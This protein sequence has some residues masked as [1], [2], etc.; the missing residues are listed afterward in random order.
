MTAKKMFAVASLL[1]AICLCGAAWE[2]AAAPRV[3]SARPESPAVGE[4]SGR[5]TFEGEPPPL[6]E[7]DMSKDPVCAA[8]NKP[9]VYLEDGKVNRDGTVPNAFVYIQAGAEKFSLTP[10]KKPAELN[11]VRCV[12]KPHVVGV[13][14][15]Q[16]LDIVSS[17][18]TTHNVRV[19]P[20]LNPEWNH[21]QPPGGAPLKKKFAHPEI[22][23]F[24]D[25]NQHPWM[26]AYIGVTSNPFFAVS[27]DDGKFVIQGV[28]PGQFTLGAWTATFGTQERK[29]TVEP[30]QTVKADFVFKKP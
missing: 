27:G 25:C 24:A 6:Q 10:P 4:I 3:P 22:M 29:V 21:S 7:V 5:I 16:E 1:V 26:E 15:G 23:I 30:G 20:H 12:Y 11:Q 8:A 28:P 18:P 2:R 13:M 19:T 14:V 9:P 17:D